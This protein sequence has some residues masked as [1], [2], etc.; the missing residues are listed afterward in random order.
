[1]LDKE[2]KF[3]SGIIGLAN[4]FNLYLESKSK[5]PF[6]NRHYAYFMVTYNNVFSLFFDYFI[7]YNG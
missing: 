5:Q 2:R 3:C 7:F 4:V 6:C 1:M